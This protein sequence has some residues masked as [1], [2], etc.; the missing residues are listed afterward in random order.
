MVAELNQNADSATPADDA[1]APNEVQPPERRSLDPQLDTAQ[2]IEQEHSEGLDQIRKKAAQRDEYLEL[3][4]RVRAD[5][6]NYQKRVQKERE[7]D[8]RYAAMPLAADLLPVIDN[9]ERAIA[10]AQSQANSNSLL[11]GIRMVY[12]QCLE[13]LARHGIQPIEAEGH[14]FD[15]NVHEAM[16]EEPGARQPTRTVLRELETGYLL[17]D[18]VIRP[19][20]VVV[21][22]DPEQR[23]RE[24]GG[25][26]G[27]D[28]S[29]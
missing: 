6:G 21:S 2:E 17:H 4:Q 20:K 16:L 9:L 23:Q 25:S 12:Q 27:A 13:A 14:A 7:T 24:A 29:N 28:N 8:R 15:P 5:Y 1:A 22:A 10:A 26:D 19:S 18:R 11:D 3:L